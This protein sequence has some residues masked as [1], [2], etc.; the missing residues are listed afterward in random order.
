[1]ASQA[2]EQMLEFAPSF[3]QTKMYQTI[4]RYTSGTTQLYSFDPPKPL[5]T[6]S[7]FQPS[8]FG[9]LR[10]DLGFGLQERYDFSGHGGTEPHLN[11][12]LLGANKKFSKDALGDA[13]YMDLFKK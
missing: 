2:L 13:H 6:F 1:M 9:V 8:G 5:G 7:G 11:Y 3:G 12:D 10:N 4:D